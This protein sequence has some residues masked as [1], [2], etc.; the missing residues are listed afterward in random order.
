[1]KI[2]ELPFHERPVIELLH[3]EAPGAVDTQYAGYGWTRVDRIWLA[4]DDRPAQPV[5]DALVLALHSADDGEPMADD[6]E[7]E[8][9][10][11]GGG[12]VLVL[13]SMFLAKWLPLLPQE[14][15]AVVLAMCNPHRA[16]LAAPVPGRTLYYGQGDVD[17]WL[18][19][20]DR[21]TRIRLAAPVW[22]MVGS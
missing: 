15:Q 14:P 6:I 13:A 3:L 18:D 22:C 12:S 16:R 17:S 9:E 7:L 1:M 20:D 5:D 10:L 2:A 19:D 11:P 21:G 4:P 8:F